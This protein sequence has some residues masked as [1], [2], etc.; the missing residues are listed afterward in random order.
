MAYDPVSQR[1]VLFGGSRD[2]GTA[3]DDTWAWDGATWTQGQGVRPPARAGHGLAYDPQRGRLILFGGVPAP[4]GHA[5]LGDTWEYLGL[6]AGWQQLSVAG[7]SPR[8]QVA[9][10]TAPIGNIGGQ[11]EEGVLLFGGL[12]SGG[13]ILGDTWVWR[14][15][16]AAW[17][18]LTGITAPCGAPPDPV[19]LSPRCRMGG[20]LAEVKWPAAGSGALLI[21]GQ[22]GVSSLGS[23]LYDD[24]VWNWDGT[25]WSQAPIEFPPTALLRSQHRLVNAADGGGVQLLLTGGETNGVVRQDAFVI[26]LNTGIFVPQ[27][28]SAPPGRT[29]AAA[30]FD[31]ER[32]Q[33]LLTGGK[34]ATSGQMGDTWTFQVSQGW[35]E[36]L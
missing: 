10:A 23:A 21:G 11:T 9:M 7:P 35:Q 31:E 2:P 25:S 19:D 6:A 12:S 5:A 32:G 17:V 3:L 30:A 28:G 18:P 14:G 29:A 34:S 27:L 4:G 20:A 36:G 13:Q 16:S 22:T 24:M 26:D 1:V 8:S 15:A 33:A